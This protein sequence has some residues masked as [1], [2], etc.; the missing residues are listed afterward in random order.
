MKTIIAGS[1]DC[2]DYKVL[3]ETI[4]KVPWEITHVVSGTAP[5][6]DRLGERWA[7]ENDVPL[8]KFPADWDKFGRSAGYLR[9]I[10]MAKNAEALVALWDGESPG[11]KSMIKIAKAGG[12]LVHVER[13]FPPPPPDPTFR[14]KTK[15]NRPVAQKQAPE[16]ER[17]FEDYVEKDSPP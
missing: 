15:N 3:L 4:K 7:E 9:N 17:I 1:R 14:Y 8:S 6:A 2:I 10:Q 13:V 5:G 11:T 16:P 12:L